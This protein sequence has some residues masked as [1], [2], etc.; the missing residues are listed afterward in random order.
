[1]NRRHPKIARVAGPAAFLLAVT[2]A[3]LLV[4]SSLSEEETGS[5]AVTAVGTGATTTSRTPTRPRR[6]AAPSRRATFYEIKAGDTLET[7]AADFDTTVE[8]LLVLNPAVDPVALGI[9]ERVRVK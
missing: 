1:M 7:V 2:V 6:P 4:R 8:R 9:G 5:P 3:V